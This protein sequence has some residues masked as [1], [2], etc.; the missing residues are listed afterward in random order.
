MPFLNEIT[1]SLNNHWQSKLSEK[2]SE[3][4]QVRFFG[5]AETIVEPFDTTNGQMLKKYP[6]IINANGDAVIGDNRYSMIDLDDDYALTIY[7][8][9]ESIANSVSKVGF[10]DNAGDLIE[11]ANLALLAFAFRKD[12]NYAS[13]DLEAIL[14]DSIPTSQK[15]TKDQKVVQVSKFKVG[16]SSFDKL[17]LLAREYAEIEVNFPDLIAFEMK[18]QIESTW[19]KGCLSN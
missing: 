14:K 8:R 13:Y 10:G 6:A 19:K 2:L 15:I 3:N 12:V 5:I 17:Q 16:N 4:V 18:Y 7:H 11:T 9:L 1:E